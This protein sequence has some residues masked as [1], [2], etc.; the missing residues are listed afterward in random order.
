MSESLVGEPKVTEVTDVKEP[1]RP[2]RPDYKGSLDV[3][4]WEN[5]VIGH[6]GKR[7]KIIDLKIGE[8]FRVRLFRSDIFGDP[9]EVTKE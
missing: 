1:F 9:R 2:R 3:A 8:L 7:Y 6:D 4:G 5:V